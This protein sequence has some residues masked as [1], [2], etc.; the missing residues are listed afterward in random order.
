MFRGLDL[1][2]NILNLEGN[3]A[4]DCSNVRLD[5]RNRL[6][7]IEEFSQITLPYES[8]GTPA[9]WDDELPTG[10]SIID[11]VEFNG[12][13]I[14]FVKVPAYVTSSK[15]FATALYEYDRDTDTVSVIPCNETNK[16]F[17]EFGWGSY[18]LAFDGKVTSFE[19]NGVLYFIGSSNS[20]D[21]STSNG[22]KGPYLCM[23]DGLVWAGAGVIPGYTDPFIDTTTATGDTY[24]YRKVPMYIDNQGNQIFG[25]YLT[26]KS[27]ISSANVGTFNFVYPSQAENPLRFASTVS[28]NMTTDSGT[29]SSS[30]S[31]SGYNNLTVDTTTAEIG[32]HVFYVDR[33]ALPNSVLYRFTIES[34]TST[35]VDFKDPKKYNANT[36]Q[37]EDA[38][39]FTINID[40][41]TPSNPNYATYLTSYVELIYFS[42]EFDTGYEFLEARTGSI[43]S[44]TLPSGSYPLYDY[45]DPTSPPSATPDWALFTVDFDDFYGD[46]LK[47][48]PPAAKQVREY[49]D[50]CLLMDDDFLYHSDLSINGTVQNFTAFDFFKVGNREEGINKSFFSDETFI[51]LHRERES[52]YISGNIFTGN[53]RVQSYRTSGVGGVS[54]TSVIEVDGQGLFM[55]NLGPNICLENLN[56]SDIGERIEPIFTNDALGLNPNLGSADSALDPQR[57]LIYMFIE[58]NNGTSDDF[59]IVFDYRNGEWFKYD[60]K[61]MRG[62]LLTLRENSTLFYSDGTD[63]FEEDAYQTYTSGVTGYWKQNFDTLGKASF[64]KRFK[65]LHFFLTTLNNG[66]FN[67]KTYKDWNTSTA[68][69]DEDITPSASIPMDNKRLNPKLVYSNSFEILSEGTNILEV[70]GFEYSY[71][72]EQDELKDDNRS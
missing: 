70:D 54:P 29:I 50:G 33:N 52:Y 16:D 12:K 51:A 41:A 1:R 6:V 62:G 45:F 37:W 11:I 39:T 22:G 63:L 48:N 28:I 61:S 26:E 18:I 27:D 31:G 9:D 17:A 32:R 4:R 64:Q 40:P 43:V 36:Q 66:T 69:T 35:T 56:L 10:S 47:G 44:Y 23:Y 20:N 53:Y 60:G 65:R 15:G 19:K 49:A 68:Y 24:F 38:G 7:K 71:E 8:G 5:E 46:E 3:T 67:L 59:V 13:I 14:L 58:S 2:S 25:Q 57:E 72:I 55:S 21:S 42:R 34:Y 30:L